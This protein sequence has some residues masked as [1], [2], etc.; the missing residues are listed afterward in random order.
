MSYVIH[1]KCRLLCLKKNKLDNLRQQ[2]LDVVLL[3]I[4]NF[5]LGCIKVIDT[6]IADRCSCRGRSPFCCGYFP[7]E[8]LSWTVIINYTGCDRLSGDRLL[9]D[10]WCDTIMLVLLLLLLWLFLNALL[11]LLLVI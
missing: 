9:N 5:L 7:N 1:G 6:W 4:I 3:T 8:I 2:I 10:C 11:L